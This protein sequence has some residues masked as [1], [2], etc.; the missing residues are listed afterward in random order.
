MIPISRVASKTVI[1]KMKVKQAP[2]LKKKISSMED[3]IRDSCQEP[4]NR[5][6]KCETPS[7][8]MFTNFPGVN[9]PTGQFL[10]ALGKSLHTE[11]GGTQ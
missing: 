10:G 7:F 1:S 9:I 2:V 5:F 4:D 11:M 3:Y 8:V 6:S